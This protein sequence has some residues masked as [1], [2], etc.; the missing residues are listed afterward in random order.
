MKSDITPPRLVI[1][2][3]SDIGPLGRVY[4]DDSM[5]VY[6]HNLSAR[7]SAYALGAFVMSCFAFIAAVVSLALLIA[8]YGL[9]VRVALVLL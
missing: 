7:L 4:G 8:I 3:D 5:L 2:E 1:Y 9:V 6:Y